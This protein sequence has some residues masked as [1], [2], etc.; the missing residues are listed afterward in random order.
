MQPQVPMPHVWNACQ[1]DGTS[2][3][4]EDQKFM[5]DYGIKCMNPL[6]GTSDY[7]AGAVELC[8][9]ADKMASQSDLVKIANLM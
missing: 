8:G 5:S 3:D 1:S 4:P 9:G 6:Y 7:W 2:T